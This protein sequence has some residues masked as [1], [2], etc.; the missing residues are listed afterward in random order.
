MRNDLTEDERKLADL[1]GEISENCYSAGWMANTEY[2]LW[3]AVTSGP[4]SWGRSQITKKDIEELTSL[5]NATQTW[6]VFNNEEKALPLDKWK[7]LF[8]N[9]VLKDPDTLR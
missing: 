4:R 6:I 7:D 3:H 9:D 2:V 8:T 5:S 1:M